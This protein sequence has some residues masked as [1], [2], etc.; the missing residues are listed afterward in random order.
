MAG[1]PVWGRRYG[2]LPDGRAY[3]PLQ[4]SRDALGAL[5][6]LFLDARMIWSAARNASAE[7]VHVGWLRALVTNELSST[8]NAVYAPAIT[9]R[10]R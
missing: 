5:M 1:V 3:T 10:S 6:L 7:M 8:T 2:R 4:I 9:E